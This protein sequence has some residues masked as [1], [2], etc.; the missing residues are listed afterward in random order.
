MMQVLKTEAAL[1]SPQRILDPILEKNF[2]IIIFTYSLPR[3]RKEW[4]V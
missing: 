1:S 4:K 3:M 2:A